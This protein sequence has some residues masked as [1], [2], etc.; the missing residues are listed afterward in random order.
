MNDLL[1]WLTWNLWQKWRYRW[2]HRH[3][4]IG[5]AREELFA[6]WQDAGYQGV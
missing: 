2:K 4:T 6:R 1:D 3:D 5:Q